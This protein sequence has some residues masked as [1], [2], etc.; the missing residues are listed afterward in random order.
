MEYLIFDGYTKVLDIKKQAQKAWNDFT[1]EDKD[2]IKNLPNF[3]K[4]IFF[5]ITGISI[6]D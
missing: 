6:K 4:D 5:E 1:K 2:K 3:N